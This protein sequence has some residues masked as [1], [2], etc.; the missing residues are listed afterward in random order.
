MTVVYCYKL[1]ECFVHCQSFW[2][3]LY[4]KQAVS[5]SINHSINQTKT[6]TIYLTIQIHTAACCIEL[7]SSLAT[8]KFHELLCNS[9][10]H[11]RV[12]YS[13]YILP[14]ISRLNPL[15]SIP[16]YFFKIRFEIMLPLRL[17]FTKWPCS[18]RFLHPNPVCIFFSP[19]L[20][21]ALSISSPFS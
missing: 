8:Q 13:P 5:Q 15:H 10:D 3:L 17:R 16:S 18:L 1:D 2:L 7:N 20:Q 11:Y 14:N 12:H 21:Q 4:C 6:L 19:Y 9:A